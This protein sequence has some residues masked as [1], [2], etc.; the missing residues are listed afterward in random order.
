MLQVICL[1]L[2]NVVPV[3]LLGPGYFISAH[4]YMHC[5]VQWKLP[6]TSYVPLT[7]YYGVFVTDVVWRI[8]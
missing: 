6:V 1:I 4:F 5:V 8:V 7:T 2:C 3:L